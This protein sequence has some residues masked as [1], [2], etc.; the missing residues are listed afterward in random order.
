MRLGQSIPLFIVDALVHR[1]ILLFVHLH[2]TLAK[3]ALAWLHW[4]SHFPPLDC[5]MPSP[6]LT[7]IDCIVARKKWAR[8]TT[9][10]AVTY[11]C[12][13]L[14]KHYQHLWT[15]PTTQQLLLEGR[16]KH[17]ILKLPRGGMWI[18]E[19]QYIPN[20]G[21]IWYSSQGVYREVL[22]QGL[23]FLDTLPREC[24]KT[25]PTKD[26]VFQKNP[27]ARKYHDYRPLCTVCSVIG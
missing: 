3:V 6:C 13:T 25:Y 15:V 11:C 18:C 20:P 22:S 26:H 19:T 8:A 9:R 5:I 4:Y 12:H 1:S 21:N 27:V 16:C 24:I 7:T 23:I 14:G 10:L 17:C 2:P